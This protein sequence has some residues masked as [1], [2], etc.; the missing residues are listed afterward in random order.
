LALRT[1]RRG[2]F[3][4]DEDHFGASEDLGAVAESLLHRVYRVAWKRMK[5]THCVAW[6]A[7]LLAVVAEPADLER[8]IW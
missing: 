5:D 6:G 4:V 2:D 1:E 3:L 7:S 8:F